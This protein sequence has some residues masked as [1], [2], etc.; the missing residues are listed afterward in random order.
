[1]RTRASAYSRTLRRIKG[2]VQRVVHGKL[3]FQMVRGDR[4][5]VKVDVDS[6]SVILISSLLWL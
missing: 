4:V 2:V 5:A 3:D 6:V 1:M